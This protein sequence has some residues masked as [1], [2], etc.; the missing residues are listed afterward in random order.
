MDQQDLIDLIRE[1]VPP[2]GGANWADLGAGEGNFT[3]ALASILGPQ[4]ELTA[5]DKD[6]GALAR[7][8]RRL[9]AAHTLVA[10]FRNALPLAG[11]DGVLMANSLHFVAAKL[12]LLQRVLDLIRPGGRLL[13]VE[14]D[15]DHGNPWV[16]HPLSFATWR[17]LAAEAGFVSTRRIG[18]RPSR[19]LGSMYAAESIRPDAAAPKG[20]D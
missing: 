13:L 9:P 4:A 2:R 18:R 12:P 11:L 15:A 7:L 3:E 17:R 20:Q 14:Y 5:V 8:A 19:F 1:G 10:D 6:A 16:P